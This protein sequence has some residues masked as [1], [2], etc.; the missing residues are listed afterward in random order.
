MN[1]D[2]S[3]AQNGS[4]TFL[5]AHN[6]YR[7]QARES[8]TKAATAP[9]QVYPCWGAELERSWPMS[10]TKEPDCKPLICVPE[11]RP[12]DRTLRNQAASSSSIA[13][14]ALADPPNVLSPAVCRSWFVD[15]KC[16]LKSVLLGCDTSIIFLETHSV[17]PRYSTHSRCERTRWPRW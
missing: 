7:S 4:S 13:S 9:S 6:G 17:S 16:W 1:V 15:V 8:S 12:A 2:H 3:Q 11:S 10:S 14:T 5:A